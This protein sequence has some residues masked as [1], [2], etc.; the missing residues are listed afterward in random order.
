M[1]ARLGGRHSDAQT[2]CDFGHR[3]TLDVVQDG[4]GPI[5]VR[6]FFERGSENAPKLG[7]HGWV[8]ERRRPVNDPIRITPILV[9]SR[10]SVVK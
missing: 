4:Y 10:K 8:V 2:R 9:E 7:L 3:Q 5:V 1:R 6:Q